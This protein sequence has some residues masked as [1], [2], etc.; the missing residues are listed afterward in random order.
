MN[1]TQQYQLKP[2]DR[3]IIPKSAANLIQHHGIYLGRNHLGQEMFAENNIKTGVRFVTD[4]MFFK[5]AAHITRVQPFSGNDTQRR[6]AVS[7]A[8]GMEGKAYDLLSFNCE[9]YSNVVQNIKPE[10]KQVNIG[11]AVAALL[12]LIF[13]GAAVANS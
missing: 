9:H 13:G 12:M 8:I 5:D 10:S 4:K 1:R 11:L 2:A 7:T 3:V 6:Q